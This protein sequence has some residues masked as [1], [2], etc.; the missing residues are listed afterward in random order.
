MSNQWNIAEFDLAKGSVK[1]AARNYYQNENN[2]KDVIEASISDWSNKTPNEITILK[3]PI[4]ERHFFLANYCD[5][6]DRIEIHF[7]D[8]MKFKQTILVIENSSKCIINCTKLIFV[9]YD[10]MPGNKDG[11]AKCKK[12]TIGQP[13]HSKGSI[14]VGNP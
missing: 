10:S 5:Q 14:I 3:S 6:H 8:G 13:G 9:S 2:I 4:H 12:V 11:I 1:K 7:V